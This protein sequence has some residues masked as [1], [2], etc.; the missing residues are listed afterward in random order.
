MLR[1]EGSV[2]VELMPL[3]ACRTV[4]IRVAKV[5]PKTLGANGSSSSELA[6]PA[7][8]LP[9]RNLRPLKSRLVDCVL[10]TAKCMLTVRP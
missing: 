8:F 2:F 4:L 7:F 3:L 5:D 10:G 9:R 6:R 1:I